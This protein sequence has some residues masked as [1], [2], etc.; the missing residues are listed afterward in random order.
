MLTLE[1]LTKTYRGAPGPALDAVD[2]Q[3]EPGAF[4]ALL[5]PNGAGK[6]TLINILSGRCEQDRGTVRVA[7]RRLGASDPALRTLIGIVPQ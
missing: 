5:G 1:G 6:S 2:L 7:G 3:V 4:L